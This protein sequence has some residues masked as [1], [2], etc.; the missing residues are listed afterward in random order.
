MRSYVVTGSAS[1]IG[2]ATAQRLADAGHR[3][4]GVDLVDADVCADL[5]TSAGRDAMVDGVT[6]RCEDGVDAVIACAGIA[7]DSP[8]TVSINFFGAVATL[9]GLRPLLARS[10]APRAVVIASVASIMGADESV[11]DACLANDEDAARTL[12]AA[13]TPMAYLTSKTAVARWVR[14]TAPNADW[15]GAGIP[16]NAIAPGTVRTPMTADLLAAEGGLEMVDGAVPMPLNGHAGPE[17]I[18]PLLEFLAGADNTHVTG[19]VVFID[20]GADAVLRGD[21]TW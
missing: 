13:N 8:D 7:A 12:M 2:A 19:Q 20:G 16:L 3:V 18:A 14:R 5:S 9:E 21:A 10:D 15:A 1:G 4:V 6:V 17:Q 11:V